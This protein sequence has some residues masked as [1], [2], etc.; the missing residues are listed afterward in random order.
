[1]WVRRLSVTDFR[2]YESAQI[3]LQPGRVVLLGANG[4]GK[5]NLVEAIGYAASLDSHRVTSDA[6]LV[7][8]QSQRAVIRLVV[9]VR[10]RDVSVEL[11]LNPGRANRGRVNGAPVTRMR[12]VL[13]ILRCI[14]FAPEDLRLVKGDPADRR[15][16]LDGLMVQAA[17]RYVAVRADFDRVLKQR[18]ALLR[19]AAGRRSADVGATLQVWNERYLPIAAELTWGRM[20]AVRQLGEPVDAAYDRISPTPDRAVLTYEAASGAVSAAESL[21]EVH[22]HLAGALEQA[23]SDEIRRGVTLVG[24]QRDDLGISLNG[25][26]AKVFASHGESWSLALALRLA[27]FTVLSQITDDPPVLILD[28]VFAE[29]DE[30]RRARLVE[31]VTGAEQVIVTAAVESDVPGGYDGQRWTVTKDAVSFV[32][33]IPPDEDAADDPSVGRNPAGRGAPAPPRTEASVR[34]GR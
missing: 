6:A 15:R 20:N 33:P 29:L 27:S 17:P 11:E 25:E 14:T 10:G 30:L 9:A 28:D 18:N 16:F 2:S 22:E 5:T 23:E 19:S 12:E 1:V 32:S 4:Q 3:E 26:P 7:R 31:A 13:G 21:S 24:P 8:A 34:A